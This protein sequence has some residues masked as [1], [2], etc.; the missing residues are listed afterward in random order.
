MIDDEMTDNLKLPEQKIPRL[1]NQFVTKADIYNN[2]NQKK[3]QNFKAAKGRFNTADFNTLNTKQEQDPKPTL[4][5]EMPLEE[6]KDQ[7]QNKF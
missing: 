3:K 4:V 6:S 2:P 5:W 1:K 7:S